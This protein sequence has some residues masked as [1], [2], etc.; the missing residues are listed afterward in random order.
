[1]STNEDS[2]FHLPLGENA[3]LDRGK[4]RESL[5]AGVKPYDNVF[6]GGGQTVV[7]YVRDQDVTVSMPMVAVTTNSTQ[8]LRL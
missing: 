4:E 6:G 2:T 7:E 1:L 3:R 8:A 5:E